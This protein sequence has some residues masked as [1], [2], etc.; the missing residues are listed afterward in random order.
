MTETESI[1]LFKQWITIQGTNSLLESF[2]HYHYL[3]FNPQIKENF[4][5]IGYSEFL[6]YRLRHDAATLEEG[7]SLSPYS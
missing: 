7:F 3:F 4:E 1:Q 2:H 6:F 5:R